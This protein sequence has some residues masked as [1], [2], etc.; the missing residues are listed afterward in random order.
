[1][2]INSKNQFCPGSI[3]DPIN[4]LKINIILVLFI[5]L[6]LILC[7]SL[8]AY[9]MQTV[10]FSLTMS[11][12]SSLCMSLS[13]RPCLCIPVYLPF[14]ACMY[15]YANPVVERGER[16]LRIQYCKIAFNLDFSLTKQIGECACQCCGA[17]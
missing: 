14:F 3:Q 6:Y 5:S 4:E 1:M 12:S 15:N 17:G 2:C 7:L 10:L 8:S 9:G 13:F 11:V 16:I